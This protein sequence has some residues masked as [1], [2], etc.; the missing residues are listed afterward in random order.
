MV[1]I[2]VLDIIRW[3]FRIY[4][5]TE[6]VAS[7]HEHP[8]ACITASFAVG[9]YRLFRGDENTEKAGRMARQLT[10]EELILLTQPS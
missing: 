2:P 10:P 9:C 1:R 3:I 6:E 5:M 7:A 4:L 8:L